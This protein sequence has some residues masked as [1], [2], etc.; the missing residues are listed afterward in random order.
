MTDALG[1]WLR[2]AA[3]TVVGYQRWDDALFLH[4][5]VPAEHLRQ[6]VDDSLELDL[7]EGQGYVSLIPFTIQG[8]RLRSMPLVP[9]LSEFHEL[10]LRT[11]VRHRGEPGVWFFSLDA[12]S[13]PAVAF[14]RASLGLPYFRAAMHR[15]VSGDRHEYASRRVQ[16]RREPASFSAAWVA[17]AP[18][19]A[20]AGSLERFLVDR[21]AL[22]TRH[23]G[24]LLRLRVRHP[25]WALRAADVERLDETVTHAA[26]LTVPF[27]PPLAQFSEGVDVEFFP[28]EVVT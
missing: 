19:D 6:H 5:P 14:A 26:H 25:P 7:F 20:A 27:T 10:N 4:W 23:V 11:Y 22:Y 2:R 16:P 1:G 8:A 3:G 13:A 18:L 24:T 12:A 17:G 9:G 21:F 28:P 15:E